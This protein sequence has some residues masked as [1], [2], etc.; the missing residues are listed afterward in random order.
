MSREEHI[1][2]FRREFELLKFKPE[3]DTSPTPLSL[4]LDTQIEALKRMRER[5][6]ERYRDAEIGFA[7]AR[8]ELARVNEELDQIEEQLAD[9]YDQCDGLSCI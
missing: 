9:L 8:D 4:P 5:A 2:R 7:V 6:A 3:P 1:K